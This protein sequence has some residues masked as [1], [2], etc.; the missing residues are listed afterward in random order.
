M[1]VCFFRFSFFVF[2]LLYFSFVQKHKLLFF[3]SEKK[4]NRMSSLST[5]EKEKGG[6]YIIKIMPEELLRHKCQTKITP[7][8]LKTKAP[9][10]YNRK[11]AFQVTEQ[12]EKYK[13][14]NNGDDMGQF[15]H[16]IEKDSLSTVILALGECRREGN[17]NWE[18]AAQQH[19]RIAANLDT[20]VCIAL[21]KCYIV[22]VVSS[23]KEETQLAA[24]N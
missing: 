16:A 17:P 21:D 18:N 23:K 13:Q 12:G 2:F 1:C 20:F 6:D 8:E 10:V 14:K 7:M 9:K 3:R 4:L 11:E 24:A 5:Q 22:P 15:L 19:E